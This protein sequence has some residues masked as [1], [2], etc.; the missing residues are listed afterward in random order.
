MTTTHHLALPYL[1]AGQAQKH[2]TLNESL[3]ILDALV[4]LSV[5]DRDLS[6]P[7]AAPQEGARYIVKAPG[8]GA[9][10]GQDNRIAH[11]IDGTWL[12]HVPRAGW[13]CFVADEGALLVFDGGDWIAAGGGGSSGGELQNLTRLGVGTAADATNPFAAKLNN[14]LWTARGPGEGGDGSLRYKMNKDS[15]GDTLSLL[16]QTGY[17]GRAEIGLTGD[18]DVHFKVSADGATWREAIV[19]DK[20]SGEV[21]FP[22]TAVG[23]GRELLTANRTYYVRADGSDSN[24]GLADSAAGAFLTIQKAVDAAAALDLGLYDAIIQIADGTW[25][26]PVSLK[27]TLG[28]GKVILRGNPAAPANV[29]LSTSAADA[30]KADGVSGHYELDGLKL[31]TAGSGHGIN[32]ASLSPGLLLD[33]RNMDFGACANFHIVNEAGAKIRATGDYT[34]SGSAAYHCW[35]AYSGSTFECVGRTVILTGTPNFSGA[36]V[37]A[38]YATSVAIYANAFSG[39]ATGKRYDVVGNASVFTN[40]AGAAALPGNAA[41]TVASGGQY[42]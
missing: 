30:V 38:A 4:M 35:L 3:R 14:A 5:A 19:I 32:I 36:F 26:A 20:D 29:T 17:E 28:A 37:R 16:M 11:Y 40:A 12:F 42:I 21:S 34:I 25:T 39:A 9:F 24:T 23:G 13:L 22:H 7:P 31:Q 8:G 41:G 6:A 1:Q 27:S 10:A 2:I 33:F 15:A 18:D